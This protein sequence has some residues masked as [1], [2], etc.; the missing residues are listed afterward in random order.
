[1][2]LQCEQT[3]R[4][5]SLLK[6]SALAR[7]YSGY[8][9]VWRPSRKLLMQCEQ[10]SGHGFPAHEAVYGWAVNLMVLCSEH[11]ADD[12]EQVERCLSCPCGVHL[13]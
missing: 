6:F 11:L 7:E 3:S 9:K 12:L 1:M 4:A 5:Y 2:A 8:G 10:W 13:V